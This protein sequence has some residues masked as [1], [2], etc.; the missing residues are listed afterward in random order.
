MSGISEK[1]YVL[2]YKG[3]RIGWKNLKEKTQPPKSP[4]SKGDL[5]KSPLEKGVRGLF[6]TGIYPVSKKSLP[7]VA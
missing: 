7:K 1:I 5:R 4:F 3:L 2:W 6:L